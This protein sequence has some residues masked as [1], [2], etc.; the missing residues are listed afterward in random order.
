MRRSLRDRT[1]APFFFSPNQVLDGRRWKVIHETQD[2]I[3]RLDAGKLPDVAYSAWPKIDP[4]QFSTFLKTRGEVLALLR[5][6]HYE[7]LKI[8]E[9]NAYSPWLLDGIYCPEF[10]KPAA[11]RIKTTRDVARILST[12]H[13]TLIEYTRCSNQSLQVILRSEKSNPRAAQFATAMKAETAEIEL[14]AMG[15]SPS[16]PVLDFREDQPDNE[17]LNQY[18][19][20]V[21]AS[22]DELMSDPE[23]FV[24]ELLL[25]GD[26]HGYYFITS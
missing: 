17:Q 9:W 4:E 2:E 15:A 23:G 25:A 18:A 24:L 20:V 10:T 6:R 21:G 3:N 8:S 5:K 13:M 7:E 16:G 11:K 12:Q 14:M 1:R 22:Q 19:E 26:I